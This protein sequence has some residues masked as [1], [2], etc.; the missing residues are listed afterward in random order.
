METSWLCGGAL[1]NKTV[2]R[3]QTSAADIFERVGF[4]KEEMSNSRELIQIYIK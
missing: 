2:F 4:D 3:A 1:E